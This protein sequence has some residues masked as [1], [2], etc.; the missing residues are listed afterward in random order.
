MI[1]FQL[2]EIAGSIF[3]HILISFTFFRITDTDDNFLLIEAA[4]HL[5]AWLSPETSE[6]RVCFRD[7]SFIIW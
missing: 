1:K 6:N 3:S 5:P 7:F 2:L 4:E